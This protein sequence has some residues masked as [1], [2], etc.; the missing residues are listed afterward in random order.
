MH[1]DQGTE[2]G[3]R[4]LGS[5]VVVGTVFEESVAAAASRRIGER[6]ADDVVAEEPFESVPSA[7]VP[8]SVAG[9]FT[10]LEAGCECGVGF[11]RLLIECGGGCSAAEKSAAAH[12]GEA[13]RRRCLDRHEPVEH[14]KPRI[15]RRAITRPAAAR[16]KRL[17]KPGVVV[18]HHVLRPAPVVRCIAPVLVEQP[19]REPRPGKADPPVT[20]EAAQVFLDAEDA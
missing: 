14:R 17:A 11:E 1:V 13:A 19:R 20:I 12:W 4:R 9:R 5:L 2:P 10:C 6:E 18:G 7:I 3:E 15:E 8:G 16:D